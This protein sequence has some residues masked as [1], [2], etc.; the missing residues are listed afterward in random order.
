MTPKQ[1]HKDTNSLEVKQNLELKSNYKRKY[2]TIS[3]GDNV[4]IYTKMK[5]NYTSRKETISKWSK[6]IYK[7]NKISYDIAMNKYY[8]LEGLS[9]HYARHE[10]LLID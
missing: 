10:L 2:P 4:K 5:G 9:R 8:L 6:S 1:A 7:V 3:V